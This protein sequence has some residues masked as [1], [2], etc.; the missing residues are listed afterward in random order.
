MKTKFFLLVLVAGFVAAAVASN[1][2]PALNDS[3]IAD[4]LNLT[5]RKGG[6]GGGKGSW[7]SAGTPLGQENHLPLLM[8]AFCGALFALRV[9]M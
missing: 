6:R 3:T 2:T 8:V 1:L 5:M 9:F 4:P 7:G